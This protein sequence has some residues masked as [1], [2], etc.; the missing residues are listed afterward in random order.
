MKYSRGVT[1]A[2]CPLEARV[3]F[4]PDLPGDEYELSVALCL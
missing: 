2:F 3:E 4:G 1:A